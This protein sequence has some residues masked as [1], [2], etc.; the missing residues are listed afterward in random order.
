[1]SV[2]E[3]LFSRKYNQ[4]FNSFWKISSVFNIHKKI[5]I[6]FSRCVSY[7]KRHIGRDSNLYIYKNEKLWHSIL[8]FQRQLN[9]GL[10]DLVFHAVQSLYFSR[11]FQLSSWFVK[12]GLTCLNGCR[13]IDP[14]FSNKKY[15]RF[16]WGR[17][18]NHRCKNG[19]LMEKWEQ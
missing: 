6:S 10:L 5:T 18:C 4:N 1:M 7:S 16:N 3:N 2:Y 14:M 19:A 15:W 13:F 17:I 8:L 12:Q 11:L 9:L